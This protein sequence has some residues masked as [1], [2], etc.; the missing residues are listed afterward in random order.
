MV[1]YMCCELK[2]NYVFYVNMYRISNKYVNK[3]QNPQTGSLKRIKLRNEYELKVEQN[4]K[5]M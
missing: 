2:Y 1:V 4:R 5:K 3:A